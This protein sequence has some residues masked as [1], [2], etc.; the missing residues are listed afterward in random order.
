MGSFNIETSVIALY[1]IPLLTAALCF[2]PVS[3]KWPGKIQIIGMFALLMTVLMQMPLI[4]RIGSWA[5]GFR[6]LVYL[7]A[8]SGLLLIIISLVALLASL[9]AKNYM[10]D[11]AEEEVKNPLKLRIFYLL[12]NLFVLSMLGMVTT[13]NLGVFWIFIE[14]STLV[15]A[16]LVGYYNRKEPV[17]AAWKYIM[18]CT[19]GIAFAL[20]GLTLGYYAVIQ[21]GGNV[22]KALDW[23][24]LTSIAPRLNP[25]LVKVAFIFVLIGFGTKAG[26]APLHNW[27]PDAHSEAPTPVSALLSGVL[28]KC[29]IYGIVRYSL[30]ANQ[31][32]DG[33]FANQFLIFFG[34]LSLGIATPFILV[35]R[36]IKRLLAYSS[37][38]HIGI[39]TVGLGFG[40]P[41]AVF[42]ALFHM[43]NH[44]LIK[45]LMFFTVGNIAL[46]YH[47]KQ[48]SQITGTLSLLPLGGT[49]LLVGGLALA[50][51]PPFSVFLSEFYV[52]AGGFQSGLWKESALLLVLLLLIFGGLSYHL[53]K[54][55][56]GSVP[57][58][59]EGE[60]AGLTGVVAGKESVN[61]SDALALLI[62]VGL[63]FLLGLWQ[64][65]TLIELLHHAT[66]IINGVLPQ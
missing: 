31:A 22:S 32:I 25:N 7:D 42:G 8:L 59:A 26:L 15:S 3:F 62:P 2:L 4:V 29:A 45:S 40:A 48:M 36:N 9:Y 44:S 16:F 52:I 23:D 43:L 18:L 19:V 33:H 53:I 64:P 51:S 58:L 17:E 38:E 11:E 50:G 35:Q 57:L 66:S 54:M 20:I 49:I 13:R 1:L 61:I 30:I 41:T 5:G 56:M 34:L 24:Y 46:K 6:G 21:A 63:L 65:S 28:L 39:I 12:F 47:S 14:A 10:I 27:L 55:S 37:L 60:Q